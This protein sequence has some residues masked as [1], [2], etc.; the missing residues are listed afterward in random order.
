[1][2]RSRASRY[3]LSPCMKVI[4]FGCAGW[5]IVAVAWAAIDAIVR[6]VLS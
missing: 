3:D 6:A 4:L 1:M 5:L 2:T